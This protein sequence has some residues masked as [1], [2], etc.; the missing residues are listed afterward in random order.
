M[1]KVGFRYT[2]RSN[3]YYY[4]KGTARIAEHAFH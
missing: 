2:K 3:V 1:Y 4:I